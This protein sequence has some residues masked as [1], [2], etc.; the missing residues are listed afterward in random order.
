MIVLFSDLLEACG[1][2]AGKKRF[3][4]G[5]IP[6]RTSLPQ[7]RRTST[8]TRLASSAACPKDH[9]EGFKLTNSVETPGVFQRLV[10]PTGAGGP[11]PTA[12]PVP[13]RYRPK[14]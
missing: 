13:L 7:R 14:R 6:R 10:E 12:I 11:D 1:D 8:R 3:V 9:R 5:R 4:Q 2:N